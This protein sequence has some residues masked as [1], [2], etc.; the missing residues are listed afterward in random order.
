[1]PFA[2]QKDF[3]RKDFVQMSIQHNMNCSRKEANLQVTSLEVRRVLYENL[4]LG[5]YF[6]LKL[7]IQVCVRNMHTEL[8]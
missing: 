7:W 6:Q 5:A 3:T 1:M 8:Q 2:L 4:F